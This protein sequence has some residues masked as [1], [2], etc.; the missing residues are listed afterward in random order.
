MF[1]RLREH[2]LEREA[3]HG[4]NTRIESRMLKIFKPSMVH[5]NCWNQNTAM[6]EMCE[7]LTKTQLRSLQRHVE[8][9]KADQALAKETN[10]RSGTQVLPKKW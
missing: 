5:D 10:V 6:E 3:E 9:A 1:E 2:L 7:V 8:L 4:Q